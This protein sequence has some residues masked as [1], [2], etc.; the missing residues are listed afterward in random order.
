VDSDSFPDTTGDSEAIASRLEALADQAAVD[1]EPGLSVGPVLAAS[2]AGLRHELG[3]LRGDLETMRADIVAQVGR[4][5]PA[6]ESSAGGSSGVADDAIEERLAAIEDTLD[7]LAERFEALA[8]DSAMDAGE[9]LASLDERIAGLAESMAAERAAAAE[10]RDASDAATQEQAASL[11]EWAE[12]VRGGL[13]DLGE[14]VTNSLG[15]L[16]ASVTGGTPNRDPD[17]RQL[18]GRIEELAQSLEAAI[19]AGFEQGTAS[20]RA[21]IE[22]DLAGLRGDLADAL[23]EVRERVEATVTNANESI[24]ASLED[25]QSASAGLRD[26]LASV[27][28]HA[29]DHDVAVGGLQET[30]ARLDATLA[31]LQRDWRPQVDAVV[32]ESRAAAQTAV[33]E[34]RAEMTA[35]LADMQSATNASLAELGASTSA[36]LAELGSSTSASL[37][38]FDAASSASLGELRASLAGQVAAIGDVTGS[39][40][41]GTDRLVGA[42]H[43]LLAYLGERDRWLERE[44]DRMLHEVLDEFAQGLSAKERRAVAGRVGE[45]LNRR[46]DARDAGRFR[47]TEADKPAIEIPAVPPEIAALSEPIDPAAQPESVAAA[48]STGTTAVGTLR[49]TKKAAAKPQPAASPRTSSA[50]KKTATAKKT[51]PA[52]K[53]AAAKKAVAKKVAKKASTS[54]STTAQTG[55]KKAAPAKRTAKRTGGSP[56]SST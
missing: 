2:L 1:D 15:S 29:Q 31:E 27:A 17:Q 42:G 10:H 24:V 48:E 3:A 35:A 37:A 6:G 13:Q 21:G 22:A 56:P 49:S 54:R 8:R 53:R 52:A 50:A 44:R 32:A 28:Q 5:V 39:L 41:G 16:S 45:A 4:S 51:A 11:D 19:A 40:G 38:Q 46:R 20:T 43:A 9:R 36:S 25:H 47:R 26:G 23:D 18:A 7:G 33:A 30:V 34:V 14:A 55:A 12:A